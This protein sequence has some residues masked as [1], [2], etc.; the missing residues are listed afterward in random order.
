M[1]S[2]L[3]VTCPEERPITET[4]FSEAYGNGPGKK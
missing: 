2:V 3:I 1:L 4:S